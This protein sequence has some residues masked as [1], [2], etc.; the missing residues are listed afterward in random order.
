MGYRDIVP[1]KKNT[2]EQR[3]SLKPEP[4]DILKHNGLEYVTLQ[5]GN[6]Y[7]RCYERISGSPK[8]PETLDLRLIV[9][10]GEKHT[11]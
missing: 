7:V 6:K 2:I 8:F 11:A 10:T 1:N 5:V 3:R 9:K 4:G